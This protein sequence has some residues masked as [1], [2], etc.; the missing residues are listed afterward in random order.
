MMQK[1]VAASW[2]IGVMYEDIWMLLS[3]FDDYINFIYSNK[4]AHWLARFS[5]SLLNE[6]SWVRFSPS[7]IVHDNNTFES[8]SP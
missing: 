7:W 5:I 4:I 2:E 6:I 3:M 1:R 8:H